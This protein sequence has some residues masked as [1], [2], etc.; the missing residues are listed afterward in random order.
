MQTPRGLITKVTMH[1]LDQ[2]V[3]GAAHADLE[4]IMRIYRLFIWILAL[5]LN[6]TGSGN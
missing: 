4:V 1:C 6:A 3:A 5:M 2:T